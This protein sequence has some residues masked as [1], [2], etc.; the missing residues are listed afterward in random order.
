MWPSILNTL[1]WWQWTILAAIPPAIVLL[2]FLKLK[3][4]PIEVPS[5]Y[6]WHKS[7]EDLHVNT[8]WQRLRR[9][10]LLFLQLLVLLLVILAVLRPSWRGE[11]L[12]GERFIFL[13]D[14][15]ASMQATDV[16]PSRLDEAKRQ[17]LELIDKMKPGDVGMVISFADAARVEQIFTTDRGKLR[18][19]VERIEASER[20]TSLL[21]A[22]KVAAGLANPGRSS[23]DVTDFQVA[24]ARPADVYIV[25]DGKF[26]AVE[27]FS[28]GNLRP[29]FIPVGETDAKN[30]AVAAF[31]VARS[32]TQQDLIH[33][34]ARL[35]NYGPDPANVTAQ[36]LLDGEEV[37]LAEDT[38]APGEATGISFPLE[39]AE[40]GILQ[41]VLSGEDD[42]VLDDVAH[43]VLSPPQRSRVLLVTA[44]NEPLELALQT[45]SAM[46]LAELAVE[47]PAYL[48]SEKYQKA[49]V[50]GT[51][52]LVI[53]DRCEPEEMP[54]ANTLMLGAVPPAGGW[55]TGEMQDAPQIID[56]DAAHPL[57]QWI[58]LGDVLVAEAVPLKP[59]A[60]AT[61]LV[62]SDVG[63]LAAVAPREGYEDAVLGFVLVGETERDGGAAERYIGTNWM[64]KQSFPVF[65]YNLFSY[66]GGAGGGTAVEPVLPGEVV[67]LQRLD[68]GEEVTIVAPGGQPTTGRADEAGSFAFADTGELGVYEAK[69]GERA[70]R[71]FAV[72]LFHPQESNVP[73]VGDPKKNVPSI[74]IGYV[75]VAGERQ[76]A[77]ARREIWRHLLL[78][79]LL[80]LAVEWYI[81][82]RRVAM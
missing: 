63:T 5:T 12:I 51:W 64:T 30:V 50:A 9:N 47:T 82:S 78:V 27:N 25:S 37:A 52:D 26:G 1:S 18:R 60:G 80:V 3:R 81:Y 42:F 31:D 72:N 35:E 53:Y 65:V 66:L 49:A 20:A 15:S 58:D 59:P 22:L 74:R 39:A 17:T 2:Y 54:R 28:L 6:L 77:P 14:T 33:A 67:T 48:N 34:F 40:K 79:G 46:E 70:V 68:P 69:V 44:G 24:E 19:A 73:L 71:Q 23:E 57:M 56:V 36:L 32:E 7:I 4:K 21:E 75:E 43:L 62:D 29:V 55:S 76:Y 61:P 13:V 41:L 45:D 38:I 10:L 8:I 11:Q 16:E